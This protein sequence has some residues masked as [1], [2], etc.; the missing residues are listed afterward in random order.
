MVN[1]AEAGSGVSSFLFVGVLLA[2]VTRLRRSEPARRLRCGLL[3]LAPGVFF[4]K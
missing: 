2:R 4:H 3:L 1:T